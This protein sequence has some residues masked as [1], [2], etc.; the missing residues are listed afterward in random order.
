MV[1]W[2]VETASLPILSRHR[3]SPEIISS[4]DSPDFIQLGLFAKKWMFLPDS[5]SG[6]NRIG[7]RPSPIIPCHRV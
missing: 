6:I 3:D 4:E 5:V 7:A 1:G 2:I